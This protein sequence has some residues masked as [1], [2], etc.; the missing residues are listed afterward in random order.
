MS[1]QF[2]KILSGE[3]K[4]DELEEAQVPEYY[5][6]AREKADAEQSRVTGLREARRSL[7]GKVEETTEKNKAEEQEMSQFR[8][9]QVEKARRKLVEQ[10][11]LTE[12]EEQTVMSTFS[13]LDSKRVDADLIFEDM[14][15]A[16]AASQSKNF[17]SLYK[18]DREARRKAEAEAAAQMAGGSGAGESQTKSKVDPK[19]KAFAEEKGLSI[20]DAQD[21]LSGNTRRIF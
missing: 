7:E 11:G 15:S 8:K 18:E 13:R 5:K 6:Y 10:F 9:E 16:L 1:E 2:D 20:E 14:Q 19:V 12:E 21:I 17:V 4:L 3:T